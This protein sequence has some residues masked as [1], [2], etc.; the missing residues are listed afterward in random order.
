R[1]AIDS[2]RGHRAAER[3]DGRAEKSVV[4]VNSGEFSKNSDAVDCRSG[5][6]GASFERH[7]FIRS[8]RSMSIHRSL[9][10]SRR[11]LLLS[12]FPLAVSPLLGRA[13]A[14]D[15]PPAAS[16]PGQDPEVVKE[17]V[18]VAHGQMARVKELVARHQTL[19]K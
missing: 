6:G 19:A 7:L 16:F 10:L 12:P 8:C 14:P 2:A 3:G 18:V 9:E 15:N 11:S 13:A 5:P 17:M 4:N 1:L